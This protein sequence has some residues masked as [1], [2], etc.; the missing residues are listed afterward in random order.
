MTIYV[1]MDELK[2]KKGND[3]LFGAGKDGFFYY[4]NKKQDGT[5]TLARKPKD[6]DGAK[7]EDLGS[8]ESRT[9]DYGPYFMLKTDERVYFIER[10]KDAGAP[11]INRETG[12]PY[13]KRDGSDLVKSPFRMKIKEA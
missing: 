4:V 12:E 13:K 9:G 6:T 10:E 5:R 1:N 2:S 8:L 7:L 11:V 3:Y